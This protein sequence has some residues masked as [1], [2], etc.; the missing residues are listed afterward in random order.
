M[1]RDTIKSTSCNIGA[2]MVASQEKEVLGIL[3]FVAE[4]EENGFKALFATVDI[5]A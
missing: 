5:V 3:D 2:L 1:L 4:K